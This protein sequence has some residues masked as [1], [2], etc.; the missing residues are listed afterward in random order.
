ML[1]PYLYAPLG[2]LNTLEY[3]TWIT[4]NH[5]ALKDKASAFS[6]LRDSGFWS[7]SKQ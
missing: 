3:S 4:L 5:T 2:M 6:N 7:S 1:T